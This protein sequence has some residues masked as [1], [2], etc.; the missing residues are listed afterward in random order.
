MAS[1][2]VED[3]MHYNPNKRMNHCEIKVVDSLDRSKRY[4]CKKNG[5]CANYRSWIEHKKEVKER[6]KVWERETYER[7]KRKFEKGLD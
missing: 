1:E 2:T 5:K 6:K 7:L 3:C 4:N